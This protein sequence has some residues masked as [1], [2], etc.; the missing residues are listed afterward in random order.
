MDNNTTAPPEAAS[1]RKSTKK[2]VRNFSPEDRAAH[3]IFERGRR[4]AFKERLT[5]LAGQLPGLAEADPR[6]LSKHVVV[7]ESIARH[8]LLESRCVEALHDIRSLVRERDEL[9]AEV[10]LWR[11]GAG[12]APR[13][14]QTVCRV[15]GLVETE[16]SQRRPSAAHAWRCPEQNGGSSGGR[17]Q[18]RTGPDEVTIEASHIPRILPAEPALEPHA[19]SRLDGLLLNTSWSGPPPAQPPSATAFPSEPPPMT[20]PNR[21]VPLGSNAAIPDVPLSATTTSSANDYQIYGDVGL[22]QQ[23]PLLNMDSFPPP[24][25]PPLDAG[26]FTESVPLSPGYM[27]STGLD[28]G[29]SL[30]QPQQWVSWH[31]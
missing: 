30:Q 14:P 10:N 18:D 16:E 7:D 19:L 6:H 13:R 27:A 24:P 11:H 31:G 22:H 20:M 4:E 1:T 8:K 9:L 15:E 23:L 2:R 21:H 26:L 5:E 28:H 29:V 12:T 25:P 17:S 3:R